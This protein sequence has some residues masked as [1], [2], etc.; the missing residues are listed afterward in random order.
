MKTDR[1]PGTLMGSLIGFGLTL[2]LIV[3]SSRAMELRLWGLNWYGYFDWYVWLALGAAVIVAS[4]VL[5][6]RQ[7]D[8]EPSV[9]SESSGRSLFP[10]LAFLIICVAGVA[11]YFFRCQTYFLG[12]GY[13]LLSWLPSGVHH[14]PWESG[15][16]AVQNWL[17]ELIGGDTRDALPSLQLVSYFSGLLLLLGGAIA[18]TRLFDGLLRRLLFLMGLASGGYMLLFFGYLESY[19]LFVCSIGWFCLSGLMVSRGR[20]PRWLPLMPLVAAAFFHIF[21][22]VLIPAAVFILLWGSSWGNRIA[23]VRRSTLAMFA[24]GLVA[25]G[26]AVFFYLYQN[27]LFF[28]FTIVPLQTDQHTVEGYWLLSW[29]HLLDYV[30]QLFVLLPGILVM[31]SLLLS[32]RVRARVMKPDCLFLLL[33]LASSMGLMFLINP[34]L[35]M[36]RDWDL[37]SFTGMPLVILFYYLALDRDGP[38]DGSRIAILGI[39]LGL[40]LLGPRVATQINP[41]LG[42]ALF[43]RY[44]ALDRV[45]NSSG[46]FILREYL[47]EQGRVQE[48]ERRRQIDNEELPEGEWVTT[49]QQLVLDGRVKAGAALLFRAIESDPSH[50]LAWANLGAAYSIHGLYDSARYYLEVAAARMPFNAG[51]YSNLADVYAALGEFDLAENMLLDAME[52]APDDFLPR[53]LLLQLY[54]RQN[55][56]DE[57]GLLLEQVA[58][59]NNAPP[60]ILLEAAK[61]KLWAFDMTKAG[62]LLNRALEAGLDSATVCELQGQYPDLKLIRCD[63]LPGN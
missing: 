24:I 53:G 3:L 44:A 18:A 61:T 37:F 8:H 30:N 36:P 58:E 51:I 39:T 4:A 35:G 46:R 33:V 48:A 10:L 47:I 40:L 20:A 21:A 34:G 29:N 28:R 6:G 19:P 26:L 17:F 50:Y 55:R 49:G 16:F 54:K 63:T 14:K 27:S 41:E 52:L 1:T 38:R 12:D 31:A 15:T 60:E 62:Q 42:I 9:A 23:A 11:F 25:V 57:Y 59:R 7:Q 56:F 43:D 13:Q 5:L 22:V 45:K 32:A 2:L